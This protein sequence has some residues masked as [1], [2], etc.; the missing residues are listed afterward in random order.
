A[1]VDAVAAAAADAC[2][3]TDL[4]ATLDT[5]EYLRRGGRIGTAAAFVGGLLDVKPIISFEVGEVTAA[6]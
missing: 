5:L 4:Y 6:G 1:D 3:A 2:E